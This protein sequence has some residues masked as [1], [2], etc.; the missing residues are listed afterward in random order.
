MRYQERQALFRDHAKAALRR[1][2]PELSRL[3]SLIGP[4]LYLHHQLFVFALFAAAVTDHFGD[5]LDREELAG[6]MAKLRETR[7]G[8]H[9][10]R[11]EALVRICYGESAFYLDVP[12]REQYGL[13]WAVLEQLIPPDMGDADLTAL[14]E[15]AD[16]FGRQTV[17][18]VFKSERL[19][20]FGDEVEDP[21]SREGSA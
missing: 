3:R 2:A 6:L 11:A 18:G 17:T 16:E 14:L 19:F 1:D 5:D 21:E 15:E 8:L 10:L 7:P 9:W 4:D 13:M 12:Q 20:G